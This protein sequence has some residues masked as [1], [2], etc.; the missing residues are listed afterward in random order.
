M[1]D[2]ANREGKW[3]KLNLLLPVTGCDIG[4]LPI[5]SDEVLVFGGWNKNAQKGVFVLHRKSNPTNASVIN[6][7]GN[8][9][10]SMSGISH[11]IRVLGGNGLD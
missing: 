2:L 8:N 7:V 10:S 4:C 6:F 1:L 11:E 9:Y 5:K 3:E